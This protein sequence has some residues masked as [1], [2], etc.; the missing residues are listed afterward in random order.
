MVK[1][2]PAAA[3]EAS[4]PLTFKKVRRSTEG[5]DQFVPVSLVISKTSLQRLPFA[6]LC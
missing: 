3:T 2:E 1:T 5:L 6:S 4:F